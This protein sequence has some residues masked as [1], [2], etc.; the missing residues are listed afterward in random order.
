MENIKYISLQYRSMDLVKNIS[1]GSKALEN[2]VRRNVRSI[3]LIQS[4]IEVVVEAKVV[5]FKIIMKFFKTIIL[6]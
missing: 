2:R 6:L 5:Y 1:N 3:S 4:L